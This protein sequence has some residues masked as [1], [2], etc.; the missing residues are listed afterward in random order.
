MEV[1]SSCIFRFPLQFTV[2][3]KI[4]FSKAAAKGG[5][6]GKSWQSS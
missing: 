6:I 4:V 3:E 5:Q 2:K 1:D